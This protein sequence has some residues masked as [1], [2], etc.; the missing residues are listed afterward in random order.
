MSTQT[1]SCMR[2]WKTTNAV[3]F[4]RYGEDFTQGSVRIADSGTQFLW[5]CLLN[6]WKGVGNGHQVW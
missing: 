6:F 1:T 5:S 3:F 2:W 4:E